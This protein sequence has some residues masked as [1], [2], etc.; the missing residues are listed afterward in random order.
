MDQ[1]RDFTEEELD[2]LA[3]GFGFYV[4]D[5]NLADDDPAHALLSKL[6]RLRDQPSTPSLAPSPPPPSK[7]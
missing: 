6:Y 2:L 7:Q 4:Q 1:S 3:H 5:F